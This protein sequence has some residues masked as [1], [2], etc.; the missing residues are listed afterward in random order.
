MTLSSAMNEVPL[1]LT[2]E[3][4]DDVLPVGTVIPF[5]PGE[6]PENWEP[7][8]GQT[9]YRGD[10]PDLYLH[11]RRATEVWEQMGGKVG[12]HFLVLPGPLDHEEAN[13]LVWNATFATP[14]PMTLALKVRRV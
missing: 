4:A 10:Y 13:R 5:K 8:E 1:N 6:V 11:I 12:A 14:V 7:F 3:Q 2:P 9:L